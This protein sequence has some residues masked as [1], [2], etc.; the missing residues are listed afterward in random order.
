MRLSTESKLGLGLLLSFLLV[1]AGT[2]SSYQNALRA[3]E[4]GNSVRRSMELLGALESLLLVMKDVSRSSMRYADT[5]DQKALKRYEKAKKAIEPHLEFIKSQAVTEDRRYLHVMFLESL[6]RSVS[7]EAAD[8]IK[9]GNRSGNP[10]VMDWWDSELVPPALA[11]LRARIMSIEAEEKEI[12]KLKM[13][14]LE[15]DTEAAVETYAVLGVMVSVFFV[16]FLLMLQRHIRMSRAAAEAQRRISAQIVEHAPIGIIRLSTDLGILEANPVFLEYLG[17]ADKDCTGKLLPDLIADLPYDDMAKAVSDGS[18]ITVMSAP[19]KVG[20]PPRQMYWDFA[21]WPVTESNAVKS[22]IGLVSDVSEKV[23]LSH[24]KSV[25]LQ[26]V[27][28]DM[29]SPLLGSNY[30]MQALLDDTSDSLADKHKTLISKVKRSNEDVVRMVRNLLEVSRYQ[31]GEHVLSRDVLSLRLLLSDVVRE[32]KERA[33]LSGIKIE[34]TGAGE[35][36]QIVADEQA[37]KHLFGN[38]ID[39]A[40]KYSPEDSVVSVLTNVEEGLAVVSVSDAGPGIP[41]EE[42]KQLFSRFWQ[43]TAGRRATGGTGLGLY[44]CQQIAAASG[45][46]LSCSSEPGQGSTFSVRMPIA[47]AAIGY[48]RSHEYA[49][50][51]PAAD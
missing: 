44:L 42:R 36:I 27:T 1:I 47:D 40:I 28:H 35:E 18:S 33:A 50:A 12:L 37:M 11:A 19:V 22:A 6:V 20:N 46:V 14:N 45:A 23:N 29:K 9:S 2:I 24:Q 49:P 31:E 41:E 39:N 51:G 5:Q 17:L 30:L 3:I 21:I 4:A 16:S 43:G 25:F 15:K 7:I 26:T 10:A 8:T 32:L 13:Y 48:N 38:L 34:L